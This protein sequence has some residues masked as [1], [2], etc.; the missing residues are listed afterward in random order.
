VVFGG[1]SEKLEF[2]AKSGIDLQSED[3]RYL[4]EKPA[5]KPGIVMNYLRDILRHGPLQRARRDPVPENVGKREVL[6][7]LRWRPMRP[8]RLAN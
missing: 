3:E 6:M 7:R 1:S 8:G 5:R 4:T 2:P